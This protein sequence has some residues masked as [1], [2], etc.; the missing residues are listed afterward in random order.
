MPEEQQPDVITGE[1]CPMCGKDELT[2]MEAERDIPY[3]G[4]VY[5]FSMNCSACKYHKADVEPASEHDPSRHTFEISDEND[6][7]VRVVR[8]STATVKIP[9]VVSIEPGPASNGY[10]TNI[11]GILSRVKT[12]IESARDSAEDKADK[13]KAKKLLK[14]LQKAM[15]G[16]EKLKLILEDP[17]GNSAIISDKTIVKKL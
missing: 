17:K 7:Q 10:I 9:H 12:Q 11:E 15:W 8:S 16:Q 14:K 5:L 2:L 13:D 1:K 4:Q 3:F 6:M